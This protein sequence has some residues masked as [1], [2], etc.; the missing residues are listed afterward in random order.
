MGRDVAPD[1]VV[2]GLGSLA[3]TP[4]VGGVIPRL[5]RQQPTKEPLGAT[6]ACLLVGALRLGFAHAPSVGADD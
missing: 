4:A 5:V 2:A 1:L 3:V 6:A